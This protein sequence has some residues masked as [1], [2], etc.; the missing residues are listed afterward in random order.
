MPL[1]LKDHPDLPIGFRV[2]PP[3]RDVRIEDL[4]MS[5]GTPMG[6]PDALLAPAARQFSMILN[7]GTRV[8]SY[9]FDEAMRDNQIVA[10]SMRRDAFLEG[11]FEERVLPTINREWQLEVDDAENPQQRAV[12]D[13]LTAV[14]KAIPD[15]DAFKR[16][17]LDGVWFGRA[18]C[19][20]AYTRRKELGNKWGLSR[21]DPIHGDSMQFTFDGTPAILLDAQTAAWYTSNGATVG[22]DGDIRSTDRGGM[23]LVLQRPYWRDRFSV[24]VHM[25]RKADYFEGELAGSVQ[26]LGL[27]GLVYWSYV[28]R[29]DAL[30]WML[31]YMQA[32]GQ[33]DLLIFNYPWNDAAAKLQQENNANKIIGKAAIA[34]PRD[35]KGTWPA[36]EQV[37]MNAA[38]LKALQALLTDYFDRHI[39]RLFVGQSMSAGAD[40]GTGL[41]GTGRAEFCRATKDEILVYDTGRLDATFTSDLVA[42]LLRYNYP[43]ADFPVRF[44]SIMPDVKAQEKM[45]AGGRLITSGVPIKVD[46]YREA[47]RYSRPKPGDE[48]IA[49]PMPGGPPVLTTMGETGPDIPLTMGGQPT[50]QPGAP[51]PGSTPGGAVPGLAPGVVPPGLGMPQIGPPA[52]RPGQPAP[53]A[54][55]PHGFPNHVYGG[56]AGLPRPLN[57]DGGGG[58]P[59]SAGPVMG[60]PGGS[61][62]YLPKP[63]KRWRPKGFTRLSR[64]QAGPHDYCSTQINL[65]GYAN[66][67]LSGMARTIRPEDLHEKGIEDEAHVTVRYGLHSNVTAADVSAVIGKCPPPRL[68][69]GKVSVFP[70]TDT[71]KDYDVLK[72]DVTS[73]DLTKMNER[74]GCLP[75]TRTFA[76]HP[77]ATIAYLKKGKGAEYAAALAP[78]NLG[79]VADAVTFS[80]TA[81]M[82][83]DI[84][85]APDAVPAPTTGAELHANLIKQL[86]Q[87]SQVNYGDVEDVHRALLDNPNDLSLRGAYADALD[88]RHGDVHPLS[89][90]LR[91]HTGPIQHHPEL[92]IGYPGIRAVAI[93]RDGARMAGRYPI[94]GTAEYETAL[95]KDGRLTWRRATGAV[96]TTSGYGITTPMQKRAREYAEAAGLPYVVGLRHNNLFG[97]VVEP[98]PPPPSP[99][100]VEVNPNIPMGSP[101]LLARNGTP[102]R[103]GSDLR[104][105]LKQAR[106]NPDDTNL[107]GVIADALDEAHPGHPVA[108]LIRKQFGYGP[109]GGQG[110]K[111]NLWHSAVENPGAGPF[112]HTA[113]LGTHGPFDIRLGHESPMGVDGNGHLSDN[114]QHNAR[115]VVHAVSWLPGSSGFRY[116]FEFPH[117]EAHLIPQ[118]FPPAREYIAANPQHWGPNDHA[119]QAQQFRDRIDAEE[120]ARG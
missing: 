95:T 79:I 12:R 78:L 42:P 34:C 29:T 62:T 19:Q 70:G 109:Y 46:E 36:V 6:G 63:W 106:A 110:E 2:V 3:N 58:V 103:Y 81:S 45:E 104:A 83:T 51:V 105:L 59:P 114:Q 24:H 22:P 40:K 57:H 7:S 111:D 80:D 74:L 37:P 73:P 54:Q 48:V 52:G 102:T 31:G 67:L 17:N 10:R 97:S 47:G 96:D 89:Q 87:Y 64:Y 91:T 13:G 28:V 14:I 32:V 88:E 100:P 1:Q 72:V 76:Y 116:N 101:A 8:Y 107:H 33:M 115:W 20:W 68:M 41:G 60:P 69:L 43:W 120:R 90:F 94:W 27:R 18:G 112:P 75:N 9:R 55:G 21:W 15:F 65:T 26:G 39:E 35:P 30:T 4:R 66:I 23:A 108:D 16:A 44:K 118:M 38:G 113:H 11:L 93:A 98:P 50:L 82:K 25:R 84:I 5:D 77:H 61:N 49:T 56:N 99:A 117:E 85:L 119:I 53:A 86:T 71:G 92:G